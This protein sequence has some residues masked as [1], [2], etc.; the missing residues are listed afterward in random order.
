MAKKKANV[1]LETEN[2][3][4][5]RYFPCPVCK[6]M[7]PVKDTKNLKPY[8]IC[9]DCGMQLF[10]RGKEGIKKFNSLVSELGKD[11]TTKELIN[12]INYF[13]LLKNK[14]E[15]IKNKKPI[16]GDDFDLNL[17]EKIIKKE[18]NKLRKK[19]EGFSSG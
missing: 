18:M 13:D 16:I 10:V 7:I 4:Y 2:V 6:E 15:E 1:T 17:Q 8:F 12:K 9:N 5:N 3:K 11:F 14:L 19:W